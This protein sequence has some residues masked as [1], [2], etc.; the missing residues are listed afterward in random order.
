MLVR[1]DHSRDLLVGPVTN[2]EAKIVPLTDRG[3]FICR[4]CFTNDLTKVLDLKRQPLANELLLTSDGVVAT[5]PLVLRVCGNCGLGQVG[6]FAPPEKIFHG[7]PYLSSVSS[8]WVEH[9][10]RYARRMQKELRLDSTSLVVEIGSNDGYLLRQ[11]LSL[12]V[13]VLGIEPAKNVAAV[14]RGVGVETISAFFGSDLARDVVKRYGHPQL[15]TANNV[16]AHVP[17]LDDF[18]RGIS[19]LCDERTVVTVENPSFLVL[20]HEAQFDTIYHE[21]FS[22]LSAHAVRV[23]LPRHG[24]ELIRVENLPT[25]GGSY[26]YWI[27]QQDCVRVGGVI[28]SA[29]SAIGQELSGG[30]LSRRLWSEFASRSHTTIEALQEWVRNKMS[31]GAR[32][33]A[34]GAAAKGNTLLNA[35]GITAG[36]IGLVADGSLEKQGKFLPGSRIPVV[37]PESLADFDPTDVLILPWNLASEIG[38]IVAHIAP[39]A[40]RWTAVPT[41]VELLK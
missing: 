1:P 33:A 10:E 20:L 6:E 29:N 22:Y 40:R 34:Y 18:L 27:M 11:F 24:L 31:S 25:H 13:P 36:Q 12:N 26:R 30:L 4:G 5:Y 8:S 35:A 41:M 39:K 2:S 28:D 21:H 17:D 37:S 3:T 16:M 38:S 14:A 15:V 7:Y 23:L 9:A 32:V 19:I